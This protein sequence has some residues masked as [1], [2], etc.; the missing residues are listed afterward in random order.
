[1]IL[2][3]GDPLML[4]PR[5]LAELTTALDAIPHIGV[6]RIHS[7]VPI[8]DPGRMTDELVAALRPRR[9]TLWFGVHCNH[10]R[11]LA[12]PTRAALAR[13]ADAGIPL[14]GQTVLLAGINDDIETLDQLARPGDG[15]GKA[16]LP[17]HHPDLVRGAPAIS[18]VGGTGPG[19]GDEGLAREGC[20]ASAQPTSCSTCQGGHG[21]VP[22]RPRL[23]GRRS[24]RA[25]GRGCV[26]RAASL[27]ALTRLIQDLRA[28]QSRRLDGELDGEAAGLFENQGDGHAVAHHQRRFQSDQQQMIA[29]RLQRQR[30]TGGKGQTIVAP[31]HDDIGALHLDGVDL[32][33]FRDRA[34]WPRPIDRALPVFVIAKKLPPMDAAA[35][36][37]RPKASYLVD[38]SVAAGVPIWVR[39]GTSSPNSTHWFFLPAPTPVGWRASRCEARR[40]ASP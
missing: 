16:L 10:P 19:P 20:R 9:A 21:K 34:C 33:L 22:D 40:G 29:A 24:R 30:D 23:S 27:P 6:I 2:T 8:V 7:R 35:D 3:G 18:G 15:K 4:A 39:G 5:R 13:L 14:M 31:G 26:R 25:P 38:P 1:V 12:A 28:D 17:L 37:A 32:D 36:A 11:E